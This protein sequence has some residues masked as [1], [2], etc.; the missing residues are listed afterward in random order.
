[1]VRVI[2]RMR[3]LA[4]ARSLMVSRKTI[5]RRVKVSPDIR[6]HKLYVSLANRTKSHSGFI[7]SGRK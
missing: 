1:M 4:W 7:V 3:C 6:A 2:F 5:F